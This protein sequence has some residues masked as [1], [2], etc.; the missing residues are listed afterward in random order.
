M[1]V[2]IDLDVER[3]AV[4][5]QLTGVDRV[6]Q[7]APVRSA[8]D[9][10]GRRGGMAPWRPMRAHVSRWG[11]WALAL[12]L[13]TIACARPSPPRTAHAVQA[14]IASAEEAERH[15]KHD[16]AR[17]HYLRAIALAGDPQS[18][19]FAHRE[20]ADTLAEWGE[21]D[22][23]IA[24]FERAIAVDANDAFSWHELGLLRHKRGD[25]DA[26]LAA[27]RQSRTLAP[28]DWRPR[29]SLAIL[30][31]KLG[32]FGAAIAEYRAM[33]D[34][35]LPGELR[36]AVVRGIE[37]LEKEQAAQAARAAKPPAGVAKP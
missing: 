23:A 25:N 20:Y 28:R 18:I 30:H 36:S 19:A 8:D 7:R 11:A 29:R 31:V 24:Q 35:D 9:Q 22:E 3:G 13:A 4:T 26:A 21:Y 14:E 1:P 5:V 10:I 6:Y 2:E 37:L 32:D 33:L 12:S 16:V 27:F 17:T 15:R 34:L